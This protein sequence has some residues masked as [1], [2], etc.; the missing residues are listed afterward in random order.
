MIRRTNFDEHVEIF[1]FLI[2]FV[3]VIHRWRNHFK[4]LPL[5]RI[6]STN[7]AN[8]RVSHYANWLIWSKV[9]W[10]ISAKFHFLIYQKFYFICNVILSKRKNGSTSIGDHA[11]SRSRD[12]T[13]ENALCASRLCG[14][15]AQFIMPTR[16][17]AIH[18]N[19]C[20]YARSKKKF[21]DSRFKLEVKFKAESFAVVH[22]RTMLTT[23]SRRRI[24]EG[25][26]LD[27]EWI[28]VNLR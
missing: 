6:R 25:T 15:S 11:I 10:Q 14:K 7:G 21:H 13:R 2:P 8:R 28:K 26:E 24:G 23:A 17:I 27:R 20:Y 9:R 4:R 18:H 3:S 22:R 1:K 12:R 16:I 5:Q 19:V